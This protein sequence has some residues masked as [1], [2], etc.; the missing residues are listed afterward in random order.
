VSIREILIWPDDRLEEISDEVDVSDDHSTIIEDLIDTMHNANGIGLSAPQIGILDRIA[1][2]DECVSDELSKH[3]V[4]LNP[5][6]IDGISD[7]VSQEGC[8]SIPGLIQHIPRAG[9]SIVKYYDE[10][11]NQI[12]L[13]ATGMLSIAIQHEIDHLDGELIVDRMNR[14]DRRRFRSDMIKLKK[15]KESYEAR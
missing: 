15:E 6:L 14:K 11:G 13:T 4:M 9:I 5:E 8:L 2:I 1:V 7:I 12:E 10:A 3:L